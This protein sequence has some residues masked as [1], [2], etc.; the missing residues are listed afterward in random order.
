M[1]KLTSEVLKKQ[2]E[3]SPVAQ[4]YAKRISLLENARKVSGAK[5]MT[6]YDKYYVGQLFENI[7]K[8]NLYE[9]YTQAGNVGNY[10]R[11]AFNI[12]SIAVQNTILPEI[13]SVQ[14]MS[15]AAQLL[16]ILELRYGTT[17]GETTAGDLVLDSTGAGKTDKYYD[18]HIVNNQAFPDN[19]TTYLAAFTPIDAG[20]VKVVKADGTVITD[21]A[22]GALSD[23]GTVN[24]ATGEVVLAAS[25]GEGTKISY[26]YNNSVVPNYLYPELDGHNQH[27]VGDVTMGINPVLIEAKEHKLRAVY[28]L[29]ASYRINKEYGVNMPLEFEKQVANEMNKERERIVM[30]D[31]FVNAAGGNSI[32]WSATPRPGVSDAEHIEG[33]P[34]AI[35]LAAAEIY[36]RTGGN[37]T[38][39]FIVAGANVVAYLAKTKNFEANEAPKNGGSFMAGRLGTLTVYQTPAL[40]TN[41]FFLGSI[42]NDFWQAGYVVGDYMPITY[43]APVTLSDFTTQQRLGIYLW[44]QDGKCK[45]IHQRKNY[46]VIKLIYIS[47][48]KRYRDVSL[49]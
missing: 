27:Q 13:V 45:T 30:S 23:G 6:A 46:S 36:N 34:I 31:M 10:K 39:N 4:K 44:K 33:L 49:F 19:A 42:G 40:G 25:A 26:T 7:Q 35:N 29:T 17:K 12:V 38:P 1:A 18:S 20:T 3:S 8:G 28:A 2:V 15:T 21:D 32:V 14:P 24:Y 5:E 9:G 41:D 47:I 43:T 11:D 22:A 37:L 16:P 48:L